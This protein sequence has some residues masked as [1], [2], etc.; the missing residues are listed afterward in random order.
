MTR[1]VKTF[2]L[3]PTE[4]VMDDDDNVFAMYVYIKDGVFWRNDVLIEGSVL[5]LKRATGAHEIRRCELF[6]H[7]GARLGD[8]V[9]AESK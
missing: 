9:E 2:A 6:G 3:L 1:A 7:H 4:T 8:R 5:E